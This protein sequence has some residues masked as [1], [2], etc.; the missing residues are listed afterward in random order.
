MKWFRPVNF[1]RRSRSHVYC[2]ADASRQKGDNFRVFWLVL[3]TSPRVVNI[4]G[5]R[6]AEQQEQWTANRRFIFL[7]PSSRTSRSCRAPRE[8]SRSPRLAHKAPVMQATT[9][10]AARPNV[11]A[12]SYVASHAG[13]F[14]GWDEKRA[15]PKT[16]ALEATWFITY[17]L[18][19]TLVSLIPGAS[20]PNS[21]ISLAT[22][23][24]CVASAM[25]PMFQQLMIIWCFGA[26]IWAYWP[27]GF[28]LALSNEQHYSP[29]SDIPS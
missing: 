19:S 28:P 16:P 20:I 15:P 12:H 24:A 13:V 2:N 7:F 29:S 25:V 3:L 21:F 8:I 4:C 23:H 27:L 1:G 11:E 22:C 6:W 26:T 9:S 18:L 10:Q 17:H 5:R 14:R